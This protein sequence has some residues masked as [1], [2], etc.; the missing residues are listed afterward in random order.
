MA[1]QIRQ[2]EKTM[3]L[4]QFDIMTNASGLV[5]VE[6]RVLVKPDVVEEK[7]AGG[8]FIPDASRDRQE[9]AQARGTLIASGGRAFEDFGSP[10]PTSGDRVWFAKYGGIPIKGA[11][12]L[13]YRLISDKDVGCIIFDERA[14]VVKDQ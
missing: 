3:G 6:F 2:R 12:G 11:D 1:G 7:T 14:E 4:E 10:A 8:I 13:M 5:P 9:L